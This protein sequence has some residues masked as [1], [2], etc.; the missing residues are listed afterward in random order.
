MHYNVS[1]LKES[2]VSIDCKSTIPVFL[3]NVSGRLEPCDVGHY[4]RGIWK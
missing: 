4:Q 2:T 1:E 3:G